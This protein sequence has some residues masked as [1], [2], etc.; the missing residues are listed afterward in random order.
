[1]SYRSE[2]GRCLRGRDL[3]PLALFG[4]MVLGALFWSVGVPA[5]WESVGAAALGRF[6]FAS[7]ALALVGFTFDVVATGILAAGLGERLGP[8]LLVPV[9]GLAQG[10]ATLNYAAGQG[11]LGA[12]LAR[13][14]TRP[15]SQWLAVMAWGM[16]LDGMVLAGCAFFAGVLL[17]FEPVCS[18]SLAWL[19]A[20][21]GGV[22]SL[23]YL[24]A[25]RRAKDFAVARVVANLRLGWHALYSANR[26]VELAAVIWCSLHALAAFG[27]SVPPLYLLFAVPAVRLV[28]ALP[29]APQGLGT[30][31]AAIVFFYSS[32]VPTGAGT[33]AAVALSYGIATTIVLTLFR[34]LLALACLP[35]ALPLLR[36]RQSLPRSAGAAPVL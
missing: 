35:L 5:V 32:F 27:L 14:S 18:F 12:C 1:M 2:L 6:V 24:L 7:V 22:F 15:I 23:G 34:L 9:V 31:H 10:A 8:S 36:W 28:S 13:V 3:L 4:I 16:L 21:S 30:T 26:I 19:A 11:V 25:R 33:G 29:L 17:S 20:G